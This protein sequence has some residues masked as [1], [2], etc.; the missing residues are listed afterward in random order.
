MTKPERLIT[1]TL[2]ADERAVLYNA[3]QDLIAVR[4]AAFDRDL[5]K[6]LADLWALLHRVEKLPHG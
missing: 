4:V 3:L 6:E 2:T 5:N 1:L